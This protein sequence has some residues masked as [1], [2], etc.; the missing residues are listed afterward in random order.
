MANQDELRHSVQCDGVQCAGNKVFFSDYLTFVI[1]YMT[2]R[3]EKMYIKK[4][5]NELRFRSQLCC[6]PFIF[7]SWYKGK[8][9]LGARDFF[10]SCSAASDH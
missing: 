6:Q 4:I 9:F 7:V 10:F 2:R 8:S 3:T 5:Y 1:F